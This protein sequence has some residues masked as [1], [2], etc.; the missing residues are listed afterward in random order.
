MHNGKKQGSKLTA[1]YAD[2]ADEEF[3]EALFR[4]FPYARSPQSALLDFTFV[5]FVDSG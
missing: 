5:T 1:D 3:K 4:I 2:D